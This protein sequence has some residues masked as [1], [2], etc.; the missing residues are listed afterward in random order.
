MAIVKDHLAPDLHHVHVGTN[1]ILICDTDINI[2]KSYS[3]FL[4]NQELIVDNWIEASNT[5]DLHI[6]L[7]TDC[8]FVQDGTRLTEDERNQLSLFH[9]QQLQ[10]AGISYISVTGDWDQRFEQCCT[11]IK[12]RLFSAS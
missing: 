6:F 11:I 9:K 12:Q 2:T 8:P 4:F 7:E 1:K 5:F 3:R 10:R